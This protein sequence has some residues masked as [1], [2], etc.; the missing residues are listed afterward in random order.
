MHATLRRS[1]AALLVLLA[2][3]CAGNRRSDTSSPSAEPAAV[4]TTVRVENQGWSQAVIYV[5]HLSQRV[6]LGEVDA[7][8]SRT[9]TVP[10][11]V[12]GAGRSVTFLADPI[13]SNRTARSFEL[14]LVR[15]DE[16]RL[17]IPP[18]AF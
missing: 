9:F 17:T 18:T 12:V 4:R 5:M 11:D 1:G 3:A 6:R 7:H 8:G 14:Q 13:G 15:G 2:T 16:L 10:E